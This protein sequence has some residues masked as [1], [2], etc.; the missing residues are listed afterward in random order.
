MSLLDHMSPKLPT[1]L[2]QLLES[3]WAIVGNGHECFSILFFSQ[4]LSPFI[5]RCY[6][7]HLKHMVFKF[8]SF[9][10]SFFL[11]GREYFFFSLYLLTLSCLTGCLPYH[12]KD[13]VNELN[14]RGIFFPN[15]NRKSKKG[16]TK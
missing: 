4:H 9:D 7:S 8:L 12:P 13:Q 2:T 16:N 15:Q 10:L 14:F 3:D 1:Q 6:N 11:V 5:L